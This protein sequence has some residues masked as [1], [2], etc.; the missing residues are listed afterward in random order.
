MPTV[1]V[2]GA[3][4]QPVSLS[5]AASDTAF[6]A[7]VLANT[8]MTDLQAGALT[9]VNYTGGTLPAQSNAALVVSGAAGGLVQ[10][11]SGYNVLVD[12]APDQIAV[13]GPSGSAQRVL[14]ADGGLLYY[15]GT[16]SSGTVLA[17]DGNNFVTNTDPNTGAMPAT[18]GVYNIILGN[19][20]NVVSLERGQSTIATG[21]GM[22]LVAL[23]KSNSQVNAVGG[24]T[25]IIGDVSPGAAPGSGSDT[26]NAGGGFVS[27]YGGFSN[28]TFVGGT[29]TVTVQGAGGS[30]TVFANGSTGLFAA[31]VAGN[32]VI[33]GGNTGAAAVSTFVDA[34]GFHVTSGQVLV[35]IANGDQLV[36]G[37]SGAEYLQAGA[38]NETLNGSQSTGDNTYFAG[39]NVNFPDGTFYAVT[40]IS[41]GAGA[42][43]VFGGSGFSTVT[44]GSG[45]T[46][47]SF[48]QGV[49]AGGTMTV[50]NFDP[51]HEQV[52]LY[53]YAA[54]TAAAA[55]AGAQVGPGGTVVTLSDNT[56]IVFQGYTGGLNGNSIA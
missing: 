7:Q 42:S 51:A 20:N 47:F 21:T 10:Q 23:G 54:G 9:A 55:V 49:A 13:L 2:L 43:T 29:G 31:G 40:Q 8:I 18:G 52:R 4:S 44:A 19:G 32:S 53:N 35:G 39:N 15:F 25:T 16:A 26:V 33:V 5:Y 48:V 24:Q 1:T 6:A 22:N 28:L 34:S 50:T 30:D 46:T 14:A 17:G 37:Q 56:R 27:V 45:N 12:N 3:N 11:P 38:G 41:T 36:A